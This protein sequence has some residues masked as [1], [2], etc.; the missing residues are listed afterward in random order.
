MNDWANCCIHSAKLIELFGYRP[1][2][3]NELFELKPNVNL[4]IKLNTSKIQANGYLE[5]LKMCSIE[6]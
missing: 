6:S 4:Y 5:F 3:R 2:Y 1:N